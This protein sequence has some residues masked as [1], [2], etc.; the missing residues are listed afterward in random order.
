MVG[1]VMVIEQNGIKYIDVVLRNYLPGDAYLHAQQL[2]D[3][4]G[5]AV[6]VT[7]CIRNKIP[8]FQFRLLLKRR[9]HV[10]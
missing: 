9:D 4:Y 10:H 1:G 5:K 8:E 6:N 3:K 2:R 7:Y